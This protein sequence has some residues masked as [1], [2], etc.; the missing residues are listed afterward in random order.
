MDSRIVDEKSGLCKRV[1]GRI[2]GVCNR[3]AR[4]AIADLS[5]QAKS[6]IKAHSAPYR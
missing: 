2:L 6:T 1:Q 5:L 3:S 4:E